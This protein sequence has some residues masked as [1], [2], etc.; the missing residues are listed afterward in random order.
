MPWNLSYNI[1][2]SSYH[3]HK[4]IFTMVLQY[5]LNSHFFPLFSWNQRVLKLYFCFKGTQLLWISKVF[6]KVV[7][8]S[9]HYY[10]GVCNPQLNF[11]FS[12]GLTVPFH[13]TNLR[14][15]RV[16]CCCCILCLIH[17]KFWV[18][19]MTFFHLHYLLH[20]LLLLLL[21]LLLRKISY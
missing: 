16:I 15:S 8:Q 6:V 3:Y 4:L 18:L 12:V 9:P 13:N 10:P 11:L 7:E 5:I 19:K 1:L 2:S 20:S 21:L 17:I 14:T